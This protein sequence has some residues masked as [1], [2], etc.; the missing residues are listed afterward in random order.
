LLEI[1]IKQNS[2]SFGLNMA[3][4]LVLYTRVT[5]SRRRRPESYVKRKHHSEFVLLRRNTEG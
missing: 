2:P 3:A 1:S 5:Y 4:T